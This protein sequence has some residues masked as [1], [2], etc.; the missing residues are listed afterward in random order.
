MMPLFVI[1]LNKERR[2]LSKYRHNQYRDHRSS[3]AGRGAEPKLP[4]PRQIRDVFSLGGADPLPEGFTLSVA[5]GMANDDHFDM[6]LIDTLPKS[7]DR[8]E[9]TG[10]IKQVSNRIT[11][12]DASRQPSAKGVPSG[13]ERIRSS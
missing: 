2:L 13:D 1:V 7:S 4:R 8:I 3:G 9:V 5:G 6:R 10:K 12:R 11:D